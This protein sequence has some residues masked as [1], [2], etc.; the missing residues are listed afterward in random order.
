MIC[1]SKMLGQQNSREFSAFH[2]SD[3]FRSNHNC[4]AKMDRVCRGMAND[5][6]SFAYIQGKHLVDH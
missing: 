1:P 4:S 3:V 5:A 6:F 2:F